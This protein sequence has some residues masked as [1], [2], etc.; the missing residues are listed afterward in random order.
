MFR[1]KILVCHFQLYHLRYRCL[2]SAATSED[3]LNLP[4]GDNA[5]DPVWK[6][7][8][9]D[10]QVGGSGATSFSLL[11]HGDLQMLRCCWVCFRRKNLCKLLTI[12]MI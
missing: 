7:A 4:Y 2:K 11:S 1:K 3:G 6:S 12:N 8:D 10:L 5:F 9:R